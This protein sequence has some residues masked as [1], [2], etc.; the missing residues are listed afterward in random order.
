[1]KAYLNKTQKSTKIGATKIDF[2]NHTTACIIEL[3]V[4]DPESLNP[5]KLFLDYHE[6]EEL[7]RLLKDIT[8]ED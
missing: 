6:F 7:V 1:M 2:K 3:T 5:Q 4:T 8:Q